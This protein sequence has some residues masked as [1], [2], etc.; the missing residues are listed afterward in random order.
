MDESWS[1]VMF[2][3]EALRKTRYGKRREVKCPRDE[4]VGEVEKMRVS[5]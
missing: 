3:I 1:K 5:L 4:S 2:K